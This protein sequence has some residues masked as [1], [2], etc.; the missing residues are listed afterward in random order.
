MARAELIVKLKKR[1]S[2]VISKRG[3]MLLG[4]WGEVGV[5]QSWLIKELLNEL[6]CKNIKFFSN[7]NISELVQKLPQSNRLPLWVENSLAHISSNGSADNSTIVDTL[8]ALLATLTPF[9][10][11]VE[12]LHKS[13][14]ERLE[15]WNDLAKAI[16]N[17][18]G[19]G[20]ITSSYKEPQDGFESYRLEPLTTIE[21]TKLIDNEAKSLLPTAA[22]AWIYERSQG[23]PLFTLEYFRYLT[24]LGHLWSDGQRW[25][26]RPP[27]DEFMPTSVEALI[28]QLLHNATTS[29][30]VQVALAAKALLPN[31][32]SDDLW[33]EITG[34]EPQKF[35]EV[36]AQLENQGILIA[37]KF[38]HSLMY[39]VAQR[40]LSQTQCRQL[41]RKA[42]DLLK[43]DKPK[44][45]AF[46]VEKAE[47][48]LSDAQQILKQA[49][50]SARTLGN[51]LEVA[52]FL[53]RA[54]TCAKGSEQVDL[55]LEAARLLS[56]TNVS[57]AAEMTRL[58][59][60]ANPN[61]IEAIFLQASLLSSLGQG[62]EAE[63]LLQSLPEEQL[64]ETDWLEALIAVRVNR[65][66]YSGSWELWQDHPEIHSLAS[67][68]TLV[69][70]GKSLTQLGMF[71]EA[72]AFFK[73]ARKAPD[74]SALD[75]ALLLSSY[76]IIPL[77]E[78]DFDTALDNFNSV[79]ATYND[80]ML[81]TSTYNS[82]QQEY[83]TS[84]SNRS[85][86]RVDT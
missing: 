75:R 21:A 31:D 52:N 35:Q 65:Y 33:E 64:L 25:R 36:K 77:T 2:K 78:G 79:L 37:S 55:A 7:A 32:A 17:S 38:A 62:E 19:I 61:N 10:L 44:E 49:A 24:R 71:T 20:F 82:I 11:Y 83:A 27:T 4:M 63:Q 9:V 12:D 28:A 68:S 3:S 59:L 53:A 69:H 42:I 58:A 45:A 72:K 13:P 50:E 8:V 85:L 15:L 74:L 47:L 70:I 23:N 40:E 54:A 84:L 16:G 76:A 86:G 29:S 66:D 5:G 46:F 57:K 18:R 56:G 14:P 41:A 6:P 80:I 22:H 30:E 1:F 34:L 43:T 67:V 81:Y 73:D 48:D 51:K 39:E 26:W 60:G